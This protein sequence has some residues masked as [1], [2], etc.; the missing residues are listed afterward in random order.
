M[1]MLVN[2]STV[3][4]SGAGTLNLTSFGASNSARVGLVI[5]NA[6]IA[7]N[8]PI[9]NVAGTADIA[10][11][12]VFTPIFQD[13]TNQAFT[14]RVVNAGTLN[15]GGPLASM[16]NASS[17]YL[18]NV[19]LAQPNPNA[20]DLVLSVKTASQLGLN[21]RQTGAYAA[22]LD[23]LE[24]ETTVAAAVTSLPGANEFLRG[25]SD[26]LPGND[27]SV[28]KVLASNST[29]AFG[30]TAHRL[31]LI[32]DK[33]DAPGGAWTEEFGVYHEGD[34]TADGFAVS[35]GGFGVAAG[36]DLIST[37]TALL[38][39]FAS[40]ES[41]EMDERSRTAAPLNVAQTTVGGYG[42]WQAGNLAVNAAGGVGFVDFSSDRKIEV[43]GISD[44][45]S[46][47]WNGTTYNAGGRATYTVPLGFL[48]A[49]PYIAA[50]YMCVP[51]GRLHRDCDGQRRAGHRCRQKRSDAGDSLLR[52]LAGRQ[53]W[54]G[55]RLQL[56][57]AGLGRL[58]QRA[59]LGCPCC[60]LPL[61][62]RLHRHDVQPRPGARAR[63]WRRRRAWPQRR[64]PVPQCQTGLRHR[65][66][67]KHDHALWLDYPAHGVLVDLT[68]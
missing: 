68:C 10:A 21:T 42:G 15:L 39:A 47:Q 45:L 12:T 51:P 66:Y 54:I 28:M 8:T 41:V 30:A 64:Q 63:G 60:R 34:R 58:P 53:F 62:R 14:L 25:W 20:I 37:G 7:G 22:V 4:N 1:S 11:N 67:Q 46:G 19:A 13:F 43:G 29:A 24:E 59:D 27:A 32:T 18:Y 16:L 23:L 6:R 3:N 65:D 61:R 2:N 26:L 50:D 48:D 44:R 40:L 17:P 31:D 49:K 52:R 36:V 56:Q 9:Y 38:G 55:R 33:P 5:N 57:A 35:G